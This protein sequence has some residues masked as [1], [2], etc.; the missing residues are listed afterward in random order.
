M[1]TCFNRADKIHQS[2]VCT[3][4]CINTQHIIRKNYTKKSII[5][6]K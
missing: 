4:V 3:S 2:D 5:N 1:Y 6:S